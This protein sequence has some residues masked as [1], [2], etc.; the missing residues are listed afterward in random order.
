MIEKNVSY[1]CMP[2]QRNVNAQTNPKDW[3]TVY[4]ANCGRACWESPLCRDFKKKT[5]IRAICTECALKAV[6]V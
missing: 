2:L 3:K 5:D 4:C 1:I 6:R